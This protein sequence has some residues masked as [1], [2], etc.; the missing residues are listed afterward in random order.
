MSRT[1]HSRGGPFHRITPRGLA[2]VSRLIRRRILKP[3]GVAP[4]H[5]KETVPDLR[6][7]WIASAVLSLTGFSGVWEQDVAN[8]YP[9]ETR[10]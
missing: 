4:G 7:G 5:A 3:A 10:R 9:V 6:S 2:A 8:S 1:K